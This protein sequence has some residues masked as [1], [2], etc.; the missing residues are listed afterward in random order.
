MSDVAVF[1]QYN[2]DAKRVTAYFTP[3]ASA[4][5][6]AFGAAPCAKPELAEGVGLW[7][8]MARVCRFTFRDTVR[9]GTESVIRDLPYDFD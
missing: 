6:S 9:A 5:A 4:L 1:S 7:L 2:I 3:S 8:E